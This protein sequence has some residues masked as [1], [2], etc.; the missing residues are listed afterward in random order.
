MRTE[1][2]SGKGAADVPYRMAVDDVL[3]SGRASTS[4]LQRRLGIG[5]N[6]AARLIEQM[7]R[8]GIVSAPNQLGVRTVLPEAA[9][10]RARLPEDP[11]PAVT[12]EAERPPSGGLD[13]LSLLTMSQDMVGARDRDIAESVERMLEKIERQRGRFDDRSREAVRQIAER[14]LLLM[15]Q[16][17]AI[18]GDLR[19]LFAFAK[20]LG[21]DPR[22][23]RA[24]IGD[25]RIDPDVR[26]ER[27]AQHAA[28]RAILGVEGPEIDVVIEAPAAA[29]PAAAK[30]ISAR[31]KTYR[32][33]MA[34]IAM[35]RIADA[36]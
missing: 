4:T 21:F 34:L 20:E 5:Y 3:A 33:S 7:A 17:D 31:E 36:S 6:S 9:A 8:D 35:S 22:G 30:K 25:L 23:L 1:D 11:A 2:E 26:K 14:A 32:D 13:S 15:A 28:Y 16:R 19:M 10:V 29:V 12:I 24:A 27:E 18:N